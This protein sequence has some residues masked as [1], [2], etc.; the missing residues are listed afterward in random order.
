MKIRPLADRVIVQR[1]EAESV[2]AGGIVLPDSA[3]E[4]P[5]RGKVVSVGEGKILEDGSIGKMQ[6]KKGDQVLF[7][8]YAGTE[9]KIDGK[10]YLIMSESDIMAILEE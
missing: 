5:Q 4:K 3:K 6:V 9:V 7:S 2:T 8:S 1:V 10:E